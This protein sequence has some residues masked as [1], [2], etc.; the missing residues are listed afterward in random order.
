MENVL[1]E[2]AAQPHASA[3][4]FPS[5]LVSFN[6]ARVPL[7]T[8]PARRS[9][10][11]G[12]KVAIVFIDLVTMVVAMGVAFHLRLLLPGSDAS[13]AHS[14]HLALG[15]VSL[16]IWVA[17]FAHY[18][19]YQANHV[20][21]RR[22]EL[23]RI[24]HAVA[25]SVAALA[26][27]GF[28]A[29]IY[30][31]RGWLVL[32]FVVALAM[33]GTER[34]LVRRLVTTLRR[35]RLMLRRVLIVGANSDGLALCTTLSADPSLGYDVVGFVDDVPTDACH[36]DQRPVL[37]S[38]D[39]TLEAVRASGAHGV[40]VMTTAV[41][42]AATNRLTRELTDAGIRVEL[43]CPLRDISVERLSLRSLG[44]FPVVH[45]QRIHRHGWRMLAK[46]SLD[47]AA[48]GA[49]LAVLA[50]VMVVASLAIKLSSR[51][52]V[53]FRQERIGRDGKPFKILKFRSMGVDAD[54]R[55]RELRTLNEADGPLFKIRHDPR[56]T[57]VGRVLRRYSIDEL[58][59]LWNVLRGEMT[60]VGPR[61]ALPEEVSGWCQELHQRLRVRPGITGMWQVSGRSQASFEDYVRL[62]LY[63]VD[64]WSL[65]V[66]L[67]IV[68]KTIPAV[69]GRRG[70]Y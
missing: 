56:V 58:P 7:L 14:R 30:V 28:M 22:E 48:A 44:G 12:L 1:G 8:P 26:L 60:L 65:L 29:K 61:P 40:I 66:D 37:G 43:M 41:G 51:G 52:P 34:E 19:L 6:G 2:F 70:A 9:W 64:N 50:P 33:L 49:A 39:E 4:M 67:A 21:G 69:L 42:M 45:V 63:Y 16:P 38:V 53:L 17:M 25:A 27:I 15:A 46:R 24:V 47:V 54:K 10:G 3:P 32:T 68:A 5:R 23:G 62:D 31:A 20:N 18:R 36:L 35:R 59:Q 13:H 11:R 57:R 55:L